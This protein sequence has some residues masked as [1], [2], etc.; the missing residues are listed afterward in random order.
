MR[1]NEKKKINGKREESGW[2][3]WPH[4]LPSLFFQKSRLP[5]NTGNGRKIIR[6]R[7]K[8][9]KKNIRK[10]RKRE[11]SGGLIYNGCHWWEIMR[12]KR[13]KLSIWIQVDRKTTASPLKNS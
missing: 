3:I 2:H 1:S 4:L 13:D 12:K 5:Q 9:V 6:E 11:P 10:K 8:E 7:V